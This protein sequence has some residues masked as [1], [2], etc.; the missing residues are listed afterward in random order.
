M[1]TVSKLHFVKRCASRFDLASALSNYMWRYQL[2][3]RNLKHQRHGKQCV[4][5]SRKFAASVKGTDLPS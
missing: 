5:G 4:D 2:F 1:R 3:H